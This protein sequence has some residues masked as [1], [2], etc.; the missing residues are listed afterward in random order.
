MHGIPWPALTIIITDKK[1]LKAQHPSIMSP[2]YILK[3][4]KKIS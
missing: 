2:K 3:K 1:K 4:K